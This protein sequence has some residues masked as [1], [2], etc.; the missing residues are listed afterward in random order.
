VVRYSLY[1]PVY[2]RLAKSRYTG[3]FAPS[4][5]GP[6]HFGSLVAA[7]ASYL[8]ARAADGRWLVRMEDVDTSR[9]QPGA[10]D[11]ILSTLER[12]GFKWDS[13]VTVQ[14]NRISAYR[15]ALKFLRNQGLVYGCG[16]TR[17]ELADSSI[18]SSSDLRYPGTCRRGLPPGR[19]ARCWRVRVPREIIA[20]EDRLQGLQRQN[21]EEYAGDFVILR[22]DGLFAYQLA[23]VVDDHDEGVTDIVRGADLLD[24]T[25][26][27]IYLQHLLG[28][29]T[30]RYLHTPVAVNALG[31]KL[32]KQT[33]ARAIDVA[34]PADSLI[35]S[36][37]FLGQRPPR[38]LRGSDVQTVWMWAIANWRP[39]LIPK[40]VAALAPEPYL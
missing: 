13:E 20:F 9:A 16:C 12:F 37:L 2:W 23:V 7:V 18:E 10:A 6:L 34:S 3:R 21:L 38:E 25:P 26:R 39:H 11:T 22:A 14:S 5:T 35:D 4:P 19:S 1:R 36:L 33:L 27:Q 15:S 8:D 40:S 29:P 17:K 30:P 24:S 28:A 31:Q 32:S